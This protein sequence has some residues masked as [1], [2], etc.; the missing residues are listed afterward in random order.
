MCEFIIPKVLANC[1]LPNKTVT[2]S[3]WFQTKGNRL[4]ALEQQSLANYL[5]SLFGYQLLQIGGLADGNLY[6][7]SRIQHHWLL[8]TPELPSAYAP[9]LA[10]AAY[11]PFAS[12]QIDVIILP[13]TLDFCPEPDLIL[14]ECE[15]LLI[16][17][18]YLL[19]IS[20]NAWFWNWRGFLPKA[21][22]PIKAAYPLIY[23]SP[24]LHQLHDL[25]F[26]LQAQQ[27]YYFYPK[28]LKPCGIDIFLLQKQQST[29]TPIKPRWRQKQQIAEY[30]SARR[31]L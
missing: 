12:D 7:S 31:R 21:P 25:G 2:I 9:V 6:Q 3:K 29:L 24:R 26:A 17:E 15:R 16:P 27:H 11:L 4:L 13:H 22:I 8:A 20:F 30:Q 10:E 19:I 28:S 23:T 14:Q 18:G 5:P 1:F